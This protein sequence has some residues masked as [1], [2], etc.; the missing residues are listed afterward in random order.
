M[1][2]KI[3]EI[4][5]K[6]QAAD[7]VGGIT[8]TSKMPC[9]SYSLPI[10]E[11]KTGAKLASSNPNSICASCYAGKG[12]YKVYQKTIEP[13]QYKRLESINSPLWIAAMIKLVSAEKSGFFRWH[14]S[15]DIQS[16]DPLHKIASVARLTPTIRHWLPTRERGIVRDFLKVDTIPDNLII[17]L[18]ALEFDQKPLT[19]NGLPTSTSH[20]NEAPHG[21]ACPAPSNNGECGSCRACWDKTIS[22]ISYS[23]H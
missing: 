21:K 12:F 2:L 13:A 3:I 8:K 23:A 20:K 17:R 5:T 11:C 10:A 14:D 6:K 7:I 19:F 22:N 16:V 1:M 18:S 4:K 15:G 9:S